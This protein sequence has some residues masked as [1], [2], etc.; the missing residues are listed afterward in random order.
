MITGLKY[1]HSSEFFYLLE[2]SLYLSMSQ[3]QEVWE[4]IG[5]AMQSRRWDTNSESHISVRLQLLS[6]SQQT[7]T[8]D[9]KRIS[10]TDSK[11]SSSTNQTYYLCQ[12]EL[13]QLIPPQFMLKINDKKLDQRHMEVMGTI[14]RRSNISQMLLEFRKQLLRY[15]INYVSDTIIQ[16]FVNMMNFQHTSLETEAAMFKMNKIKERLLSMSDKVHLVYDMV[17]TFNWKN[18]FM[19]NIH[20][21]TAV[22]NLGSGL[23]A[24]F[25]SVLDTKLN[26]D[27]PGK[28]AVLSKHCLFEPDY[29]LVMEKECDKI[30]IM[31]DKLMNVY[32]KRLQQLH[33]VL[34]NDYNLYE[35]DYDEDIP[36][37]LY[38]MVDS[39]RAK[40]E[41]LNHIGIYCLKCGTKNNDSWWLLCKKHGFIHYKCSEY[42]CFCCPLC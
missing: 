26:L 4:L 39:A 2:L 21:T 41:R 1:D 9:I 18:K 35:D 5:G 29:E 33:L 32:N 34:T 40:N 16:T 10:R 28:V 24:G 14:G 22:I 8:N 36:I 42:A 23:I 3:S 20:F 30:K 38:S 17:I 7:I 27:N 15:N 25:K 13:F 37:D 31:S 6:S 12:Q 19:V 11:M